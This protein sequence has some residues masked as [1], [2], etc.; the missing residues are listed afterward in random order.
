VSVVIL[1]SGGLDSTLV[2]VMALEE[3]LVAFPLFI[4]YGQRAAA[5]EWKACRSTYKA[6]GLPSPTRLD[7]K[8]FGKLIRSGLTDATRDVVADAFTPGRNLMFIVLGASYAVKVGASAVSIG[9]LS[10]QFHIFPDQTVAF[11]KSAA[12][13]ASEAMGQ[14]VD[15]VAPLIEFSKKQVILL[16]QQRGIDGTYSC[17]V[18][19]EVPCGR[20]ISCREF[21]G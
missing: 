16:A 18:G 15:V 1:A 13:T 14:R 2:S 3:G 4:D 9:L 17:H 21:D 11:L 12:L 8:G 10:E 19:G 6:L 20:C 7:V 5:R